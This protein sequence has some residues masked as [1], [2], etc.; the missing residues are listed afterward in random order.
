VLPDGVAGDVQV[1]GQLLNGKPALTAQ[2]QL[3]ELMASISQQF[4]HG[5][6]PGFLSISP[7]G[8]LGQLNNNLLDKVY[9]LSI[10]FATG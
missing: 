1:F 2:Q 7:D 9:Y 3:E 6:S 10:S 4:Q 8:R 5:D